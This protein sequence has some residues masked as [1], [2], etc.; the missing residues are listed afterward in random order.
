MT[1]DASVSWL[2]V[3]L[4]VVSEVKCMLIKREKHNMKSGSLLFSVPESTPCSSR[5]SFRLVPARTHI[6]TRNE[7]LLFKVFLFCTSWVLCVF[8]HQDLCHCFV[9]A[10]VVDYRKVSPVFRV[11]SQI[12]SQIA[13]PW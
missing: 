2:A 6:F 1:L 5:H 7:L 8:P 4:N 10:L 9:G 13:S 3:L 11:T 12:S